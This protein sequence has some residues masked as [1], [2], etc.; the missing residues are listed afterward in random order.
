MIVGEDDLMWDSPVMANKI[1]EQDT[2]AKI[3]FL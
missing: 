3:Y 2:K 1:R